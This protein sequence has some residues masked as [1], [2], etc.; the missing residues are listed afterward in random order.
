MLMES[1]L[2]LQ[3]CVQ[4]SSKISKKYDTFV[5]SDDKI[6]QCVCLVQKS[7]NSGTLYITSCKLSSSL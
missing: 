1:V 7:R 2:A 4:V 5:R 3:H 6:N